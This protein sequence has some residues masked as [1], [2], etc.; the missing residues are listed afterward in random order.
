[1]GTLPTRK[2][3]RTH[4]YTYTSNRIYRYLCNARIRDKT[5]ITNQLHTR[6]QNGTSSNGEAPSS[7]FLSHLISYPVISDSISTFKSNPYGAKSL[8]ITTSLS[9]QLADPLLP[10]L[11]KPYQYVS[12]YI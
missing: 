10:Y 3:I 5:S 9:H 6:P 2:S 7:A 8:S 12:P 1:M 4:T 11:T